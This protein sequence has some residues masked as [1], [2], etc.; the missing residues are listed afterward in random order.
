MLP[1]E[2]GPLVTRPRTMMLRLAFCVAGI[3]VLTGL[4][5]APAPSQ[6]VDSIGLSGP[7]ANA[8]AQAYESAGIGSD[9]DA[10][11]N[12]LSYLVTVS[13]WNRSDAS[14]NLA[15][16][17]IMFGKETTREFHSIFVDP[18]AG[19][20]KSSQHPDYF[21]KGGVTLPGIIAGDIIAAR[22]YA[23]LDKRLPKT[24]IA[25]LRGGAYNIYVDPSWSTSM[26]SFF[27]LPVVPQNVSILPAPSPTPS[28]SPGHFCLGA[29]FDLFARYVISTLD[30]RVTIKTETIL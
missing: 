18:K 29:C 25:Q 19:V 27:A 9:Q 10:P 26:M 14:S 13:Q 21:M 30:G 6:Y 22:H 23:L 15:T 20:I 17:Q 8:L 2:H 12:L 28:S 3:A 11:L 7:A 4:L 16:F 24:S 1:R 5:T